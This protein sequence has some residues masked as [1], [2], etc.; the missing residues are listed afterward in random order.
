MYNTCD[1]FLPLALVWSQRLIDV[2][3]K[4][5]L[6]VCVCPFSKT[7]RVAAMKLFPF[8]IFSFYDLMGEA[9]TGQQYY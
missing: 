5:R 4:S 2:K 7:Y 6:Y 3:K 9:A 1:F 8:C